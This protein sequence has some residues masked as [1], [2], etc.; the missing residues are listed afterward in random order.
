M[1]WGRGTNRSID[2][3]VTEE[4]ASGSKDKVGG[5]RGNSRSDGKVVGEVTIAVEVSVGACSAVKPSPKAVSN[6]GFRCRGGEDAD[7]CE[8]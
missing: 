5:G 1:G 8:E 2:G 3:A 4:D 6:A 7:E